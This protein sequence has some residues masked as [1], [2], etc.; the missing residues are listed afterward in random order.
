MYSSSK[1]A[2]HSKEI[3]ALKRGASIAPK[4]VQLIISDLC[5][6][7]CNFCAY[8]M[9]GGFSTEQFVE[10]TSKG[11]VK[12]PNRMIPTEKC[13][14]IIDSC[15]GMGV[16]AIQFTGGGEPSVHPDFN[17]ILSHAQLKGLETALVTNG[18]RLPEEHIIENLSWIRVSL[19]AGTEKTYE[20]IRE[21]KLWNKVIKN[22][23]ILGSVKGPKIGVG[24]VITKDN[25]RDLD[26]VCWLV[27]SLKIPYIRMTAMF[28]DEGSNYYHHHRS[29][30][31][32]RIQSAKDCY[33]DDDFK[34]IDLFT[35][36]L[37][38][39]DKG[40]P[41]HKFCGYQHF[42]VYI[43]GNQKVYRCCTTSYTKHGEIGDL[44]NM[45]FFQWFQE[46]S[47]G[48]Y[49]DFDARTCHHC[50]FHKQNEIVNYLLDSDPVH[51][52]FV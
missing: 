51:V 4:H 3:E 49:K 17:N 10:H 1:I 37:D 25:Y 50:Q 35:H 16:K 12:N 26:K 48:V 45:S 8:R 42:T 18:T 34:I 2:W 15:V 5:N 7:N 11:L 36:R 27:K 29:T 9:D 44:K 33:N 30:I 24:F 20:Y 21:S 38:D 28:S 32:R 52:N 19:D 23:E 22:L 6:Q 43:G 40:S 13:Y 41:K 46:H 31:E 39:L 47:Y 14:E